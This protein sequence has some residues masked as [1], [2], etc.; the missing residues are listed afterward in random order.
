MV[1]NESTAPED[2]R[3]AITDN[4]P[5]R[6]LKETNFMELVNLILQSKEQE[7]IH[8]LKTY[9]PNNIFNF[10]EIEEGSNIFQI[11][12][13]NNMVKFVK[14]LLVEYKVVSCIARATRNVN[15]CI[16]VNNQSNEANWAFKQSAY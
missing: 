6:S 14:F 11:A 5:K 12:V 8:F 7:A 13:E 4:Q 9:R 16:V 1:G 2:V 3:V 15:H 10:R